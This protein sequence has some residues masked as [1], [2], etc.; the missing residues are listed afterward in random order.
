M[1]RLT[2]RPIQLEEAETPWRARQWRYQQYGEKILECLAKRGSPIE[3]LAFSPTVCPSEMIG[4]EDDNGHCWPNYYY[5]RGQ[6]STYLPGG[7]ETSSV[8]AVPVKR[9]DL[10]K[11]GSEP[12]ILTDESN[13]PQGPV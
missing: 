5:V 9:E 12:V 3:I 13:W 10:H 4:R 8:T 11:Y 2:Q 6:S 1:L 7:R